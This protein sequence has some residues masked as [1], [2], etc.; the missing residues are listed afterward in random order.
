MNAA[1][2]AGGS[3]KPLLDDEFG[4]AVAEAMARFDSWDLKNVQTEEAAL[5]ARL[6]EIQAKKEKQQLLQDTQ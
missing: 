2:S 5:M 6:A 1:Q 3:C 4:K